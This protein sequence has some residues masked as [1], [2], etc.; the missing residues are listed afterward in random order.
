MESNPHHFGLL[1][2]KPRRHHWQ[3]EAVSN[4]HTEDSKSKA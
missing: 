3:E 1:T 4:L 2:D